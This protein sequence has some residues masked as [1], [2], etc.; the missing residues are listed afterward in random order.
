MCSSSGPCACRCDDVAPAPPLGRGLCT[1]QKQHV[2][3]QTRAITLVQSGWPAKGVHG[4]WL[5]GPLPTIVLA[6]L[7]TVHTLSM[8]MG[9]RRRNAQGH[10]DALL[11]ARAGSAR[12]GQ[13]A[14]HGQTDVA[15]S[16]TAAQPPN[17]VYVKWKSRKETI[18]KPSCDY[19]EETAFTYRGIEIDV[20][21]TTLRGGETNSSSAKSK[22]RSRGLRKSS[23]RRPEEPP[24]SSRKPTS[25][26]I[27]A[28]IAL[29]S[30]ALVL[31]MQGVIFADFR[32]RPT[33]T[34]KTP[35]IQVPRASPASTLEEYYSIIGARQMERSPKEEKSPS[36]SY[37][38]VSHDCCSLVLFSH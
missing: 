24:R 4:L 7:L 28:I 21:S 25:P 6:C 8:V 27:V 32:I 26:T 19:D 17:A 13:E 37:F 3:A 29:L 31:W 36:R 9:D 5:H 20:P 33:N 14:Q 35:G 15:V 12:H 23:R 10:P 2:Q 16:S 18:P 38:S 1:S 11:P 34:S 22:S 30:A